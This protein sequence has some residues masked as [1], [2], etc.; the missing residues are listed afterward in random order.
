MI[1]VDVMKL[2][3]AGDVYSKAIE[4]WGQTSI[5]KQS[6]KKCWE[7]VCAEYQILDGGTA[8][9]MAAN[10]RYGTACANWIPL[11]PETKA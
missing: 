6:W 8:F 9:H 3:S 10:N 7:I 1:V 2:K 4:K 11:T 5:A